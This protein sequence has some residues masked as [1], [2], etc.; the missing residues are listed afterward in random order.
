MAWCVAAISNVLKSID[1]IK[2]P[3]PD[4]Q[5]NQIP[6]S[7]RLAV[8]KVQ[9]TVKVT[10][11][12]PWGAA[13]HSAPLLGRW[14]WGRGCRPCRRRHTF[15]RPRRTTRPCA[16]CGHWA[17]FRS[18]T[19]YSSDWPGKSD[20]DVMKLQFQVKH[21]LEIVAQN[22]ITILAL[23]KKGVGHL[24]A[25]S[26]NFC[27][28]SFLTSHW[29]LRWV[30]MQSQPQKIN[31]KN[32]KT[33]KICE[34]IFGCRGWTKAV[35]LVWGLVHFSI[36]KLSQCLKLQARH[37]L[38]MAAQNPITILALQ[39]DGVGHLPAIYP[40]SCFS[41]FLTSTTKKQK[42]VKSVKICENHIWRGKLASL[43]CPCISDAVCKVSMD[44]ELRFTVY[45]SGPEEMRCPI[46]NLTSEKTIL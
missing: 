32:V 2:P 14:H 38:E 25:I 3:G 45:G 35:R 22:P 44:V 39:N 9:V 15:H 21:W 7:L 19:T 34:I 18:G 8:V 1:F 29:S 12:K 42:H 31:I 27:F 4:L 28:S 5:L 10:S 6:S 46:Y 23:Q 43:P 17:P 33:V 24:P 16:D 40:K 13:A 30:Q 26:P 36:G 11:A 20:P 37:W 41:S